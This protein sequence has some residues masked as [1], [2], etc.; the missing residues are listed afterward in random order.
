MKCSMLFT[1]VLALVVAG[2]RHACAQSPPPTPAEEAREAYFSPTAAERERAFALAARAIDERGLRTTGLL[3]PVSAELFRDKNI[4]P[5]AQKDR[6]VLVTSYRYDGDLAIYS[7]LNLTRG[8]V[9][10]VNTVAHQPVRLTETEFLQAKD[11][12]LAD[13]QVRQ[14]LGSYRGQAQIEAMVSHS[15]YEKDPLFGHR[16]VRLLF[17]VDKGYLVKPI[18]FVDLTAEQVLVD[19]EALSSHHGSHR[20]ALPDTTPQSRKE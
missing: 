2:S 17:R 12:A 3:Y 4:A 6:L 9:M 18:V 8:T 5:A 14:K 7:F 11:R 15:P 16:V 10:K 19:P 13:P 1:V 20:G